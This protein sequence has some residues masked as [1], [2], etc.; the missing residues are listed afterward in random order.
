MSELLPGVLHSITLEK[1]IAMTTLYRG[2][3]ELIIKDEFKDK[4]I[5]SISETFNREAFDR[6][7]AQSGCTGIRIYYS[8][9][10]ELKLHAIVVGVNEK[11]ED[12]LPAVTNV[13]GSGARSGEDDGMIVE[14]GHI[15]PPNCAPPSPL[16]P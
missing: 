5:L 2:K 15:C 16:N 7:L 11:N 8:I 3:K 1:A 14:E 12:I 10:E 13:G 6:L 4:K 9:D